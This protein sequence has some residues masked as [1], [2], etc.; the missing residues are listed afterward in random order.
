MAAPESR[1][2]TSVAARFT[3]PVSAARIGSCKYFSRMNVSRLSVSKPL[4]GTQSSALG[5]S[6]GE[7]S[8]DFWKSSTNVN[9]YCPEWFEADEPKLASLRVR[10]PF[11][12]PS[13]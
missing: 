13:I 6:L 5:L 10:L 12:F 2:S 8:F 4:F 7:N 11:C 9:P 1:L 3:A